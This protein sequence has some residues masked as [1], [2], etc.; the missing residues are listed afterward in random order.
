M[1]TYD[2]ECEACGHAFERYQEMKDRKLRTCPRCKKP[3]LRRLVGRGAGLIFKG[4]G[5]YETDYKRAKSPPSES[6]PSESKPSEDAAAPTSPS[7]P[8]ASSSSSRS[9]APKTDAPPARRDAPS[10]PPRG[11]PKPSPT[12]KARRGRE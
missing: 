7:P 8:G 4:S 6:K 3:R 10:E 9:T 1:P 11:E 2:Y 12:K 5:F